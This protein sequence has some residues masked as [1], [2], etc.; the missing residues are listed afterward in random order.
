MLEVVRAAEEAREEARAE[1]RAGSSTGISAASGVAAVGAAQAGAAGDGGRGGG[2]R[3]GAWA[4]ASPHAALASPHAALQAQARQMYRLVYQGMYPPPHMTC[5][6][7]APL[8]TC[9]GVSSAHPRARPLPELA[10]FNCPCRASLGPRQFARR[11]RSKGRR[12][13]AQQKGARVAGGETSGRAFWSSTHTKQWGSRR[14][15]AR[16]CAWCTSCSSCREGE[17]RAGATPIC[18]RLE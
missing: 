11:G 18:R 2:G 7:P 16:A 15:R 10:I 6:Y 12:S 3:E 8:L 14:A 1:G 4:L 9:I 5:M 17:G 13:G